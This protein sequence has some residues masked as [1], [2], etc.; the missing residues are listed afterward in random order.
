MKSKSRKWLRRI[1]GKRLM[2]KLRRRLKTKNGEPQ[3]L[4]ESLGARPKRTS[5]LTT[6]C[7]RSTETGALT[8]LR[9]KGSAV[10]ISIKT[11]LSK[12][13]WERL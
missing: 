1:R 13:H 6:H 4:P 3:Q 12:S 5:M 8:V 7:I 2:I 10:S 9:A 11:R